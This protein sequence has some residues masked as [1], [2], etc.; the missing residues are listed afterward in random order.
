MAN[1]GYHEPISELSN[2]TR[3][4]LAQKFAVGGPLSDFI[5]EE[6]EGR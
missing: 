4:E 5:I 6:R 3:E 1:E 2:E